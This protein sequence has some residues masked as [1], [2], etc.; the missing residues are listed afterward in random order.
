MASFFDDDEEE[1]DILD[2]NVPVAGP[3]RPPPRL[4]RNNR[5]AGDRTTS[6]HASSSANAAN[7]QASSSRH[8][9][10]SSSPTSSNSFL[11]RLQ[12]VDVTADTS[13]GQTTVD[14]GE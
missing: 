3:S 10:G 2:R 4:A 11:A 1:D 5:T 13:F 8:P 12:S 9:Y 14:G 6:K 7:A